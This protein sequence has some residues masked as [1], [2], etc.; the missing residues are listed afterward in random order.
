M[1]RY[2]RLKVPEVT[3]EIIDSSEHRMAAICRHPLP[4]TRQEVI[5][6]LSDQTDKEYSVYQ[7][8]RPNDYVKT[9][10]TGNYTCKYFIEEASRK[11]LGRLKFF[12][13]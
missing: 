6:I 3:G 11:S 7:E 2:L 9:I 12:Y 5:D 1:F 4:K 8:I 10:A 13:T